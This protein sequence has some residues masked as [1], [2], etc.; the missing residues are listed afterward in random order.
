MENNIDTYLEFIS[1]LK[2]LGL[3]EELEE[4]DYQIR[5]LFKEEENE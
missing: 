5:D 2:E 3:E 4:L 1:I